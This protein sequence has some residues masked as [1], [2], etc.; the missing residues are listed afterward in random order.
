MVA[1]SA[2]RAGVQNLVRSLATEFAPTACASTASCSAW[3]SRANG[4]AATRRARSTNRRCHGS[5]GARNS[6]SAKHIQL[7]RLGLPEEAARAIVF[8]A[9]PAAFLHHRRPH[10]CFR[11]IF[12]SCLKQTKSPSAALIAAFLEAVRRQGRVRRDLDPQ[13]ADPRRLRRARQRSASCRRA[14]K[15]AAPTWPTPMRAYSGG[16]GV[17]L[18]STGTAAGNAAGAMVE[19]LTAGTPLLHL[20]GQIEPPYLDREPAPISTRR[21]TSSTC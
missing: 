13:H 17:G 5:S 10:R 15:P 19:A 4:G 2:A 18:T 8:L 14:A 7:G 9:S 6:R 21:R 1:T 16:L 12:P 20:T 3:S 11:R